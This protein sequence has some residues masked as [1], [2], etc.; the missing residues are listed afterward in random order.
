MVGMQLK[1]SFLGTRTGLVA[2]ST[3]V[4][5]R[6]SFAVRAEKAATAGRWLPGVDS[7]KWLEDADLPANRGAISIRKNLEHC[8]NAMLVG[9]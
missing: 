4:R 2:R 6:L 1:G 9:S 3:P 7:P 8:T 5:A